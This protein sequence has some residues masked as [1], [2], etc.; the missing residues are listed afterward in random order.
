MK[1]QKKQMLALVLL[2]AVLCG[3][4]FGIRYYN[5]RQADTQQ[6]DSRIT[7]ID[8]DPEEL[9]RFSYTY[10]G[11]TYSYEKEDGVW[12]YA[13]DHDL[14]LLQYRTGNL[15]S[16]VAPLKT[17][18]IIENVTDM[19]QYGLKEPQRTITFETASQSYILYVGDRNEVTASY[20][21]CLPSGTEV[22][23]VDTTAI[24]KFDVTPQ[25]LVD[26]T[27]E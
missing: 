19:E 23:L 6:A 10:E 24:N 3:A 26:T 9:V 18:Q 12:Y 7:I 14:K 15:T 22:Y 1:R 27:E 25:E 5:G 4:F 21:V 20:Y 11:E 8:M 17:E 16:G 13:G 2:L